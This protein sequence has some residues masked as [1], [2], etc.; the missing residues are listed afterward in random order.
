MTSQL[1]AD[2]D[3]QLDEKLARLSLRD[4]VAELAAETGVARR[5]I[6]ERALARQRAAGPS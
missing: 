5:A 2:L 4:A 3:A 6:Y 1:A